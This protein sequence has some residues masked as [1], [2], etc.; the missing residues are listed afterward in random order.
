VTDHDLLEANSA[1]LGTIWLWLRVGVGLGAL[2][3]V[4]V[5]VNLATKWRSWAVVEADVT[6]ARAEAR[7]YHAEALELLR[8]VRDVATSVRDNRKETTIAKDQIAEALAGHPSRGDIVKA[9][10]AVPDK[11]AEKVEKVIQKIKN[12]D[13]GTDIG[14]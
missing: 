12:G 1:L 13:S 11:T 10:E 8:A 9:V 7:A 4:F 2:I 6:A 3:L 5:G 14:R